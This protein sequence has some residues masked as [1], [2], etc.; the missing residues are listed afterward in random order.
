MVSMSLA[1]LGWGCW[2]V[3]AFLTHFAP[4]WAPSV[5]VVSWVSCGFAAIGLLAAIWTVRAK[6]AWLLL[7]LIPLG[8][9][10]SLLMMPV[11]MKT[12]RVIHDGEAR[13]VERGGDVAPLRQDVR[14]G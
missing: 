13:G 11:V 1:S 14:G 3:F 6:L 10:G 9:N 4:G 2:W 8:A 12:L 5:G 7:A